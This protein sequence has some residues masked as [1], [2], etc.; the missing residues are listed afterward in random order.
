MDSSSKNKCWEILN[1]NNLN[2][3]ARYEPEIPCWE[4]A[5]RNETYQNASNT[6]KDCIAYILNEKTATLSRKQLQSIRDKWALLPNTRISHQ[7]CINKQPSMAK[8][9]NRFNYHFLLHDFIEQKVFLDSTWCDQCGEANLAVFNQT[10]LEIGGSK[11]T[12]GYCRICNNKILSEII[13]KNV[14]M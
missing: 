12:L 10:E 4:I 14:M 3:Q 11:F 9:M 8:N 5:Q 13:E 7:V 1:C 2:C 6:C